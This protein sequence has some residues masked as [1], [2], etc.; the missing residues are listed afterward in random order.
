M[1]IEV[2]GITLPAIKLKLDPSM[3][4]EDNF[5]ELQSK[6]STDFFKNSTAIVDYNG[7]NLSSAA[8]KLLEDRIASHNAEIMGSLS[9]WE[10]PN[11]L[12]S[13]KKPKDPEL[14]KETAPP[15]QKSPVQSRPAASQRVAGRHR[16]HIESRTLRSGQKVEHDGDV[17]VLGNVNADSYISAT[18]NI[19]VFGTLRGVVHAGRDGNDSAVVIAMK[20][21]PQQLRIANHNTRPP[22]DMELPESPERAY[23]EDNQIYIEKI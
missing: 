3:S 17:L 16:L 10:N 13:L 7:V 11:V 9:G 15:P 5:R 19:I 2:K 12:Q 22:D 20:M 6:L 1:A 23:V 14:K 21:A 18:G 8:K 4:I